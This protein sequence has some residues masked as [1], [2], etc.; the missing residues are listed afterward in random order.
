MVK[1]ALDQSPETIALLKQALQPQKKDVRPALP[2]RE[3]KILS[4]EQYRHAT[5]QGNRDLHAFF[6]FDF[7]SRGSC[8]DARPHPPQWQCDH[9]G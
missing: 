7:R 1:A 4:G 5:I 3:R 9:D 2:A 6:A 8:T